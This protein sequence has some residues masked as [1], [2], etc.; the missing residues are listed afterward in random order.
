MA[1][2][3]DSDYFV[4]LNKRNKLNREVIKDTVYARF[5]KVDA[6]I[7]KGYTIHPRNISWL[8]TVLMT[9]PNVEKEKTTIVSKIV[10]SIKGIKK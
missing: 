4:S 8:D 7:K 5:D 2:R 9:K 10:K 1:K 6:L 3:V